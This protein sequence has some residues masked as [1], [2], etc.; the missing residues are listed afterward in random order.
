MSIL[1]TTLKYNF[2]K[3][4]FNNGQYRYLSYTRACFGEQKNVNKIQD[5]PWLL[6]TDQPRIAKYPY[7]QA[8]REWKFLSAFPLGIQHAL[9]KWLG[10][11]TLQLNTGMDNFPDQFLVGA[12]LASRKAISMLSDQLKDPNNEDKK[13]ELQRILGPDLVDRFLKAVPSDVDISIDIPQIYDV[14]LGDIWVT[15]GNPAAFSSNGQQDYEVIRW[16]TIRV[17][18]HKTINMHIE[19]FQEYRERTLKS[20]MEGA[21]VGVDVLIDA[22]IIYKANKKNDENDIILYDEGRRTLRMRFATPYFSPA[23]KMVSGYDAKTG[24]PINDWNWCLVDI[25]QLL[26]KES[27]DITDTNS[28]IQDE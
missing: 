10:T 7:E 3:S 2:R 18:L 9:C 11:R 4:I 15:L 14:N 17:G 28:T 24:E 27:M 20:I 23:D 19:S 5:F 13:Q 6:S 12:S 8:T 22:D 16:M 21:Q 26:E 25:D 1:K